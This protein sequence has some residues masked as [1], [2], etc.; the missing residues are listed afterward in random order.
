MK[1]RRI[2]ITGA[3][4]AGVTT[5]GR[6]LADALAIPHHDTDDYFWQ[7]TIPPYQKKREIADRLRLMREMFLDRADWVLSGSL[8]GWGD[9]VIAYFDLVVFLHTAKEIRVRRLRARE[10]RHFGANAVGPG[11]WRHQ[12]TEE[13]IEW[14]SHYDAGDR[15]GRTFEKH[16]EWLAKLPCPVLRLDG[17]RPLPELVKVVVT[18]ITPAK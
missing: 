11:G 15:E 13:F 16:Q 3:S 9:P 5:L 17:A 18:A 8:E 4:G 1:P 14:A 2:H 10:A 12:E 6:A 7:P